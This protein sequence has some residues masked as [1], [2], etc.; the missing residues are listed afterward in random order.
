[1]RNK[2]EIAELFNE[3]DKC[4]LRIEM[5]AY[6]KGVATVSK[7]VRILSK[8]NLNEEVEKA[9]KIVKELRQEVISAVEDCAIMKYMRGGEK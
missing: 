1:M 9:S 7:S 8:C 3:L 5:A 4:V 2:Q 6:E